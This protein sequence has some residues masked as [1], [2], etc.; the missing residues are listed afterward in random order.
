MSCRFRFHKELQVVK[1]TFRKNGY[2]IGFIDRCIK[3]FLDKIHT[4]K[5]TVTTVEKQKLLLVLP[6]LGLDSNIVRK[7]LF[8]TFQKTLPAC[9]LNVVFKTKFR[10]SNFFKFKDRLCKDLTSG[11]IYKFQYGSCNASYYGQTKRHFK[12]RVSEHMG[13]S[14]L[15][16]KLKA[17]YYGIYDSH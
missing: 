1:E 17:P 9:K 15:T 5:I 14:P 8:K 4:P 16:G 11:I 6:Y 3:N 7:S 13:V 2:P 10:L 12:V